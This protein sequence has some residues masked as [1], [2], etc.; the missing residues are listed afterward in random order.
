MKYFRIVRNVIEKDDAYF[1]T[2]DLVNLHEDHW[3]SF[4]DRFGDTFRWK[5]E[6]VS[7]M[8]VEAIINSFPGVDICTVY[9]VELPN[10]EG[11]AGMV[12]IILESKE[13]FDINGFSKFVVENFPKYSIPIFTRI[14]DELEFTG[15][16]KLRKINLRKQGYDVTLLKDQIHIWDFASNRY[17]IF[18]KEQYQNLMKGRIK[19]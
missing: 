7:T 16:H 18:E 6:N 14:V 8:E 5:G 2:G 1:I 3:V 17:K 11:K 13:P 9:G 12:A 4:A 10:A 19:M 15:T